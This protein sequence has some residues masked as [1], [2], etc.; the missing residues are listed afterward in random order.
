ME[1][2]SS[3]QQLMAD[4]RQVQNR[5]LIGK[6]QSGNVPGG[7]GVYISTAN[8]YLV[9]Y[10]NDAKRQYDAVSSIVSRTINLSSK[11]LLNQ[12]GSSIF[13]TPPQPTTYINGLENSSLVITI[14]NSL[15]TKTINIRQFG[16]MDIQWPDLKNY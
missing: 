8:Q 1:V 2:S 15:I 6:I 14:S 9:F 10:N 11:V 13:F 5:A 16:L 3:T 4:L 12:I 7:Y